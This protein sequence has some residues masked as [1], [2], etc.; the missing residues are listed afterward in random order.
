MAAKRAKKET[1][2]PKITRRRPGPR[3]KWLINPPNDMIEW[4]DETIRALREHLQLT[5]TQMA[6]TLGT[7]QQTISE[8]EVGMYKPRGGMARLL[9][10]VAER[11]NF[12]YEAKADEKEKE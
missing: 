5:Q 2:T 3:A 9:T 10:M 1:T 12:V 4:N 7:R 11:A 6:E 8:W